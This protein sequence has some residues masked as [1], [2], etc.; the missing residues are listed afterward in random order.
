MNH[1]EVQADNVRVLEDDDHANNRNNNVMVQ[2]DNDRVIKSDKQADA[3][4][5]SNQ[6]RQA[7]ESQNPIEEEQI[8]RNESNHQGRGKFLPGYVPHVVEEVDLGLHLVVQQDLDADDS[9]SVVNIYDELGENVNFVHIL[10]M[11]SAST[12]STNKMDVNADGMNI[13]VLRDSLDQ[14]NVVQDP[15]NVEFRAE[16]NDDAE[17]NNAV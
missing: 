9:G 1:A 14:V 7:I 3:G 11:N 6:G 8:I 15:Q 4:K 2:S 16:V 13:D 12:N 10:P 17:I 5:V